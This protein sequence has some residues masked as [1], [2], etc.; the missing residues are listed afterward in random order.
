[1]FP[2]KEVL[3]VVDEGECF[4][5]NLQVRRLEKRLQHIRDIHIVHV[6][7]KHIMRKRT[8]FWVW[9]EGKLG[10]GDDVV[11]RCPESA[12]VRDYDQQTQR[13]K[14]GSKM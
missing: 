10:F 9:E 8:D 14:L 6:I 3:M 12:V 5:N 4:L 13:I 1:M 11:K 2:V 7:F